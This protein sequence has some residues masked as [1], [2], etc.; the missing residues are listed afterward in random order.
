MKTVIVYYS[1]NGNTK[2]A[3]EEIAGR[4]GADI[5][6]IRPEKAFPDKGFKKFLWGGKSAVMG[7]SPELVPYELNTA[8]YDCVIL[9]TPVWASS[10]AP[11]MRTFAEENRAAL[12]IKR[13][14]VFTCFSGGGAEKAIEKLRKFIDIEKFDSKLI[15]VDP[16]DKPNEGNAAK[17][18]EFCDKLK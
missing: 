7:E 17:I 3:A 15:L 13:L 16:K 2:Y 14:G 8:D 5:V 18:D 1:M 12:Q 10:F 11:P 9:G 4:L 6:E